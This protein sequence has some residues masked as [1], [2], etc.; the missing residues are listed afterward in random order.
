MTEI[1][2]AEQVYDLSVGDKI[3]ANLGELKWRDAH[4]I[5]YHTANQAIEFTLLDGTVVTG[6]LDE[7]PGYFGPYAT[8]KVWIRQPD[9]KTRKGILVRDIL[10]WKGQK[11]PGLEATLTAFIVLNSNGAT[12][13]QIVEA[14]ETVKM[15]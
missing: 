12:D 6:K 3:V 10:I 11:S 7:T 1:S 14:R 4:A 9:R 5:M 15:L 8:K 2:T 13:D